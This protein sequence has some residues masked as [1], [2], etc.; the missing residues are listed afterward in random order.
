MAAYATASTYVSRVVGRISADREMWRELLDPD[1]SVE[2][3]NE[4]WAA[5]DAR[6]E[7]SADRLLTLLTNG[8]TEAQQRLLRAWIEGR[9]ECGCP[10]LDVVHVDEEG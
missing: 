2:R 8:S 3:V 6:V 1:T 10:V 5:Y 9:L 4:I 7:R